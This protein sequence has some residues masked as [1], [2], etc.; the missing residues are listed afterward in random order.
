MKTPIRLTP[1]EWLKK[2]P[3][4]VYDPNENKSYRVIAVSSEG[5]WCYDRYEVNCLRL[6]RFYDMPTNMEW[7]EEPTQKQ[8][9]WLRRNSFMNE[10]ITKQEA[11][12]VIRDTIEKARKLKRISHQAIIDDVDYYDGLTYIDDLYD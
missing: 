5:L 11:W 10:I 2:I 12:I 1:V 6:M 7:G 8:I 9:D 4:K 3:C